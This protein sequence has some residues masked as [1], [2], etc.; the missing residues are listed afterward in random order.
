MHNVQFFISH[1]TEVQCRS[2]IQLFNIFCMKN[3]YVIKMQLTQIELA[4]P[5]KRVVEDRM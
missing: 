5:I 3:L 1:G 2:R 4:A